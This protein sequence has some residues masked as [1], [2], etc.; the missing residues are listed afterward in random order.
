MSAIFSEAKAIKDDIVQY[1]RYLHNNAEL[2]FE[3]PKTVKFVKETLI[4][5][6]CK[7]MD[8]GESGIYTIIGSNKNSSCIM[9]R[10]DMDALPINEKS[11]E[12][13]SAEQN[14]HACGHD[15]HTAMLLGTARLLKNHENELKHQVK[16]VFQP[17][18]ETLSGAKNLIENGILDNPKV[19]SAYMLHVTTNS[20]EPT[21][22][23]VISAPGISAPSV[24]YFEIEV[25]GKGC[26]G[27][28]PNT[29]I[30]PIVT[31]AHII[32]A[33]DTI[34][35]RNLS[36]YDCATITIGSLN[37]G[38]V[39]NVIPE[40]VTITGTARTFDEQVR[41][42]IKD[43]I[44]CIVKNTAE[45][46]GAKATVSFPK[47]CPCLLNDKD[48]SE[49]AYKILSQNL[50]GDKVTTSDTVNKKSN[51]VQKSSGSEDF[52]YYAVKVPSL[53]MGISAGS[54]DEGYT[55]PLHHPNVRF[56]EDVLVYG[57]AAFSALV[58]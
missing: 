34:K 11:G 28:M 27:A 35:T 54:S 18:E 20:T 44:E 55:Q 19:T 37:G 10:A 43:R 5:I 13:F 47:G 49:N 56:N 24:D 6:G 2:G 41:K 32:T 25:I 42:L 58:L 40:K 9:L 39:H 53:M 36:L 51:I 52:A 29:G 8:C 3:L 38:N 50:P 16:L 15:I 48:L 12:E 45:V 22:T 4:K 33:L 57:A 46:F 26:H 23:V 1:R 17:A 7:P 21:G 30:D 14:M 31:T